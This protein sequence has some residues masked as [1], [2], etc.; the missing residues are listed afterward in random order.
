MIDTWARYIVGWKALNFEDAQHVPGIIRGDNPKP[1]P[2]LPL[3]HIWLRNR[4]KIDL[5]RLN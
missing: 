5:S 4:Y 3:I 2:D 1:V